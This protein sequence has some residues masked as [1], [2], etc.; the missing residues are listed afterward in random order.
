[1]PAKVTMHLQHPV[2]TYRMLC[3]QR[4]LN[5]SM[6]DAAHANCA[7]CLRALRSAVTIASMI[8]PRS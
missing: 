1:M 4:T 5:R 3:G 6:T 8:G 7:S 2:E